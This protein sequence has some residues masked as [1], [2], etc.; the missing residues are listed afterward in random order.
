[1]PWHFHGIA[2]IDVQFGEQQVEH[3]LAGGVHHLQSH[4]GAEPASGQFPL[5]LLQQVLVAVFLDL[6]VGVAGH[7]ERLLLHHFHAG[8]Q[9]LEVRGDQ[10]L[11]RKEV[12]GA[13]PHLDE[14][15]DVVG[16]LHPGEALTA[17]L[18][19]ANDDG[20]VEAQTAD[21]RERVGRV[22]GQRGEH[23]ED[24]RG[25][26]FG[27]PLAISRIDG[28]P[29]DDPDA[30]G[31][32][33]RQDV[34]DEAASLPFDQFLGPRRDHR[35]LF[36]RRHAVRRHHGQ[37]HLPPPLQAGHPDHVELV[38]VGRED[39]QELGPLQERLV[40]ILGQGEDPLVEVEP[41][42]FPI[43]EA[44]GRQ[45]FFGGLVSAV[46]PASVT[47]SNLAIGSNGTG[48]SAVS[49]ALVTRSLF[50]PRHRPRQQPR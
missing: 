41:A 10:I 17:G 40:P 23:R 43:G 12:V 24:L 21:V 39:R 44:V 3:P 19:V 31:D 7:P 48:S 49:G 5:Q 34:L 30:L 29:V 42:Q 35:Q 20:Q 37:T 14:P 2:G 9:L 28:V 45:R 36:G 26:V 6:Q 47:C 25:E 4:R 13:A 27:Q 46:R 15:V 33:G 50:P 32:E 11:Q 16:H 1:M 8:E 38:E 22:D 18:R